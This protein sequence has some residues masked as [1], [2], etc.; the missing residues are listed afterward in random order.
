MCL[1]GNHLGTYCYV[2]G[3]EDK[4]GCRI[5]VEILR[6]SHHG[7]LESD[8]FCILED[9]YGGVLGLNDHPTSEQALLPITTSHLV[10]SRLPLPFLTHPKHL[11]HV[12]AS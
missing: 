6:Q 1:R 8:I 11:A 10:A 9:W 3:E 2:N 4:G 7:D 12:F 5:R